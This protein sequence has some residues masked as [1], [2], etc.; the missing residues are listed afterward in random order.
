[1]KKRYLFGFVFLLFAFVSC[2]FMSEEDSN[3][4]TFVKASG[5]ICMPTNA[6]VSTS[7]TTSN[8]GVSSR[9]AFPTAAS[10][11]L[12][13]TLT[14][15]G[16]SVTT[17][18]TVDSSALTFTIDVPLG[19]STI[20]AKA[21]L[22]EAKSQQVYEGTLSLSDVTSTSTLTDKTITLSDIQNGT[23][24][25]ATV[26]LPITISSDVTISKILAVV[27]T[28]STTTS[29]TV[30]LSSP[31]SG[32]TYY[33]APTSSSGTAFSTTVATSANTVPCIYNVVFD[34]YATDSNS[35]EYL[36]YQT[37]QKITAS[38]YLTTSTWTGVGSETCINSSGVMEITKSLCD[39]FLSTT[40][41]ISSSGSDSASGS[42]SNPFKSI[43]KA[44]NV[45]KSRGSTNT[46][47]IYLKSD[48]EATSD[49]FTNGSLVEIEDN[50][51]ISLKIKSYPTKATYT[52]DAA[53][54][55]RILY[56]GRG[57]S[58]T[59]KSLF[60]TKGSSSDGG[61]IY[62]KG[63][64]TFL[65]NITLEANQA[66]G[67]GAALYNEGTATARGTFNLNIA[68]TSGGG[69]YNFG[70][71]TLDDCT[72]TANR[73]DGI[74]G[75]IYSSK[76]FTVS[77]S[78]VADEDSNC[79]DFYL[80]NS[81]DSPYI[82]LSSDFS[83]T[84]G[85][86][87]ARI[88]LASYSED[89]QVLSGD[90]VSETNCGYFSLSDEGYTIGTDG[91]VDKKSSGSSGNS[92]YD[93]TITSTFAEYVEK[94]GG[95]DSLPT[96]T[97]DANYPSSGT[98]YSI[99]AYDELIYLQTWSNKMSLNS[100]ITFVLL[101]NIDVSSEDW[102]PIGQSKNFNSTFDGNGNKITGLNISG[103]TDYSAFVGK[104]MS[105]TT[106][107]NLT[108]EGSI[109]G[110][111][112]CAGIIA[113]IKGATSSVQNCV[114]KVSV[115]G[116]KIVGGIV[117]NLDSGYVI[118]CINIGS[119]STSDSSSS[120]YGGIVGSNSGFV[121]NCA[122]LGGI[123]ASA[124]VG[125][126]C[127][128]TISGGYLYNV[129]NAGSVTTTSSSSSI[130]D[131]DGQGSGTFSHCYYISGS[132]LS[133][134][135]GASGTASNATSCSSADEIKTNMATYLSSTSSVTVN[136]VEV[137]LQPWTN[138]TYTLNSV[139]YPVCMDCS[140]VSNSGG[141]NNSATTMP[142]DVSSYSSSNY[143]PSG[144]YAIS[145]ADDLVNLATIVNNSGLSS[146]NT[147]E[148]DL[149][150]DIDLKDSGFETIGKWSSTYSFVG[151]FDGGNYTISNLS[152]ADTEDSTRG[153]L[154]GY[155]EKGTIK[156]IILEN[157]SASSTKSNVGA[158][159]GKT[160]TDT[161]I[162]NCHVKSGSVASLEMSYVGGIVGVN[163]GVII[164]CSN[165]A[166]VS[167]FSSTSGGI[168]GVNSYT[169]FIINCENSGDINGTAQVG[170][171]VG[172]NGGFVTNSVNMG[173]LSLTSSSSTS[174]YAGGIAGV[175][176]GTYPGNIANCV[177]VGE[178]T[179]SSS[180][181]AGIGAVCYRSSSGT[182]Y[183]SYGLGFTNITN[184]VES[185]TYS[186]NTEGTSYGSKILDSSSGWTSA[187]LI[188]IYT[189][190]VK[191]TDS[192]I[193]VSGSESGT[194]SSSTSVT[195]VLNAFINSNSSFSDGTN[196]WSLKNWTTDSNGNPALAK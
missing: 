83:G 183:N 60:L 156:N 55:G 32:T 23:T 64:L 144:T 175:N 134:P 102:I 36:I 34:F 141:G 74:G 170:G 126:V 129:Y 167:S 162:S 139:D 177:S 29:T 178:I 142:T 9:Q 81:S 173:K 98:V 84:S 94:L 62:N 31:T 152:Y 73:T 169:G 6:V 188:N 127:G 53:E 159:C 166:S 58:V 195:D 124:Y 38:N 179:P 25:T 165:A 161:V 79:N 115:S 148:F 47:T 13:Y 108:V 49:D 154:F 109:S 14:C 87:S 97:S 194:T 75:A 41:Y 7:S 15:K 189:M 76:S 22:D 65:E 12:Y 101:D 16:G 103:T 46:C 149:T 118:N 37:T 57:N 69:I 28:G 119:V 24:A 174:D 157:V 150:N 158:I 56:V 120:Y 100:N 133:N 43:Q 5:T 27:S 52:I 132:G 153:G 45:I 30:E 26:S 163:L 147:Y 82:T 143:F 185:G 4:F 11:T 19:S 122:N 171:I 123:K 70:T 80:D 180:Q 93:G 164:N 63:K 140:S 186:S 193:T 99:S 105:K 35:S 187:P 135:L 66:T 117:G 85:T 59:I 67:R 131:V 86:V 2:N 21:F 104:G 114:S 90:G 107:K 71:L 172:S 196:I 168:A 18:G 8:A 113:Y 40:F 125:G 155:V 89:Y 72:F 181:S 190:T 136:S 110:G 95:T 112:Y 121:Y 106:I 77:G 151:T 42:F 54:Q 116:T 1:M 137:T 146:D 130:G 88:T 78:T 68:D 96:S 3:S 145:S 182:V 92:T 61:G 191:R 20:T 91:K 44:V 138:Y 176:S 51:N 160:D 39:S 17:T 50:A 48:I 10:G 128:S 111:Q 192:D 33:F 184:I